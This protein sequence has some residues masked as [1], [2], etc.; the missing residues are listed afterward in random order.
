MTVHVV[1]DNEQLGGVLAAD[2]GGFRSGRCNIR[3]AWY[4]NIERE[5]LTCRVANE[6]TA[7]MID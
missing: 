6:R 5:I 2:R 7:P 4:L 3:I 1:E